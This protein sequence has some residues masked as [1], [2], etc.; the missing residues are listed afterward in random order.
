MD[1]NTENILAMVAVLPALYGIV[2][3]I[4]RGFNA[5]KAARWVRKKYK[6]EW[7]SLHWITKRNSH[8]G[9]EA[10]ITKGLISGP[11]VEEYHTRDEYLEKATFIG[12]LISLVLLLGIRVLEFVVS[13]FG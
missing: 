13:V 11:E 6:E 7:N 3:W 2:C 5:R 8:A 9:V 4:R 10:L 12:I 1:T